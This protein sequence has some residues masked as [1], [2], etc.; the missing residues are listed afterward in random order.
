VILA[1]LIHDLVHLDVSILTPRQ[2]E[3]CRTT[4]TVIIMHKIE[5]GMLVDFPIA[6]LGEAVV[7]V[8]PGVTVPSRTRAHK[9]TASQIMRH[10]IHIQYMAKVI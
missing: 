9:I 5:T 7:H 6:D 10:Q 1:V 3:A 8:V 4:E 2:I